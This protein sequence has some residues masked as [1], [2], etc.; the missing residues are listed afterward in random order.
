M[1]IT[2]KRDNI[3]FFKDVKIGDI[4][5]YRN[6]PFMKV[7]DDDDENNCVNM[8]D[9]DLQ[10]IRHGELITPVKAELIIE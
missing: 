8:S 1:K 5:L 4:F 9:G 10:Y 6:I 3:V 2:N 7:S